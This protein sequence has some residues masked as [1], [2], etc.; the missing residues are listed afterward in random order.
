MTSTQKLPNKIEGKALHMRD[1][2]VEAPKI[3]YAKEMHMPTTIQLVHPQPYVV[4]QIQV[5]GESILDEAKVQQEKKN[6]EGTHDV[7]WNLLNML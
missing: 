4:D 6:F 3:C 2:N 5:D 7:L 1:T